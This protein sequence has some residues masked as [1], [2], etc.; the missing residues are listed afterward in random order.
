MKRKVLATVLSLCMTTSLLAGCGNGG[1]E[2]VDPTIP[3]EQNTTEQNN[4]EE[5]VDSEKQEHEPVEL[6][7]WVTSRNADDWSTDMEK[8]FLEE[9]PW[10]TLNKVVKEGDPGNEFYQAVAAGNAPDLIRVSFT[11]MNSYMA[12][13]IL[14]PLNRYVE[15]WDEW[16]NY[17]QE[18]VDMFTVDG[19]IYGVPSSVSP[20]LF[21]Y[22]KALFEEAGISEPPKTW[23]EALESLQN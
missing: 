2:T 14:E 8:Q 17:T 15:N 23:D 21:G 11:M 7:L 19:N 16:E 4:P 10:I 18:Y 1:A 20:M 3:T 22:N 9:H 13:N 5:V 6:T 12:S